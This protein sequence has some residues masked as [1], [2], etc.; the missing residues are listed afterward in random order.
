MAFL[1]R[2]I[3]SRIRRSQGSREGGGC[4]A[5]SRVARLPT[6]LPVS[7]RVRSLSP[8]LLFMIM[9]ISHC[10]CASCYNFF[11]SA[12]TSWITFVLSSARPSARKIWISCIAL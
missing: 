7:P 9:L 1:R 11:R 12:R 2:R 6:L 4:G 3:R 8:H 5:L 10:G